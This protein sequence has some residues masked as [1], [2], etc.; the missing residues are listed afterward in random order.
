MSNLYRIKVK[1]IWN[2]LRQEN[3]TFWL[4]CI[5]LFIEYVRPQSLYPT[6]DVLPFAQTI[7]LLTMTSFFMHKRSPLVKNIENRLLIGFFFVIVLSSTFA[8]NPG[9]AYAKILDFVAWMIIYF[10]IINIVNTEE[11]FL[12]FVLSFLLYNF[13][14]AQFVFRGWGRVGFG[15]A[16]EGTG[17]GPGWFQNSGEFG[18]E[19]CIFLSLSAYFVIALR[20][21][22]PNWKKL[23]FFFFPVAALMGTVSS[24]SRGALLG[25]AAV[26]FWMFFKSKHR[27]KALIGLVFLTFI[28]FQVIPEEQ[29]ERFQTAGEDRTSIQRLER[30]KKGLE[31]VKRYPYFG[32]GFENWAVADKELFDGSGRASHNIFIECMSELGFIGLAVYILMIMFSFINNSRTRKI[33]RTYLNN[34]RF[35][36]FMAHGLDGALV[37]YLVSGFFVTVLYYPYF[38]INLS[39]T[40]ALNNVAKQKAAS[41]KEAVEESKTIR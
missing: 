35:I 8:L 31:M 27:V 18:I 19:M 22:W 20:E 41:L 13:K 34:N 28:I 33:A 14:M 36:F 11:R 6:I 21:Y 23:F 7:I 12:V 9:V 5:Y 16:R 38:W 24:A 10:L 15:F 4:I 3:I 37:G 25:A 26:V 1:E 17:G 2:Y 30:W 32:V 39:M 40:V 29:F